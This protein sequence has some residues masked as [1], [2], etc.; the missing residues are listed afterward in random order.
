M[1]IDVRKKGNICILDMAGQLKLDNSSQLA[2][3][4]RELVESGERL[5]VFN[6][7]KVTWLDSAGVG[8]IVACHKRIREREGTLKLVLRGKAH[9]IFTMVYLHRTFEIFEDLES[10][11]ASFAK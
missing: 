6:M 4:C 3:K 9:E 7:L 1:T 10:A 2:T 8:E 11:L 5:F